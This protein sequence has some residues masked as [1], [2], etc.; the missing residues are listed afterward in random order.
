MSL[1][2][3]SESIEKAGQTNDIKDMREYKDAMEYIENRRSS[4]IVKI[5]REEKAH[6][7]KMNELN[8]RLKQQEEM[9]QKEMKL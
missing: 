7:E 8:E 3:K 9:I 5:Q 1:S 2:M 6:E 4:Q